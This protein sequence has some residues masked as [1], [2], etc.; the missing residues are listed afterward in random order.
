ME[1]TRNIVKIICLY[2]YMP[3]INL[4]RTADVLTAVQ[5]HRSIFNSLASM[6]WTGGIGLHY[7][8][9]AKEKE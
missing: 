3:C 5:K 2:M 7:T 4:C 9:N 8:L 6:W 1:L